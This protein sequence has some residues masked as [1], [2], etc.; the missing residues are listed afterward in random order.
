M[1]LL[2][3]NNNSTN[4]LTSIPSNISSYSPIRLSSVNTS[5]TEYLLVFG[6]IVSPLTATH[7]ELG[8]GDVCIVIPFF[9]M[10]CLCCF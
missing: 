2:K 4:I 1:L 8:T 10:S 9:V 7:D 6:I 5:N 3:Y